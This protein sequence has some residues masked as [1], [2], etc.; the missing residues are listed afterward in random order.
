M[1]QSNR[2]SCIPNFPVMK[3]L[4]KKKGQDEDEFTE[5]PEQENAQDDD[6]SSL[7]D[8]SPEEG[9]RQDEDDR[10]EDPEEENA[11][12][13]EGNRQDEDDRS[14]DPEEE[15]AEDDDDSDDDYEAV[16]NAN[17]I[18]NENRKGI[19]R[20]LRLSISPR[21]KAPEIAI[22]KKKPKHWDVLP[23]KTLKGHPECL[24]DRLRETASDLI[25]KGKKTL[26]CDTGN[27]WEEESSLSFPTIRSQNRWVIIVLSFH[28]ILRG[29]CDDLFRTAADMVGGWAPLIM[30]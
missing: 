28:H 1:L 6:D 8:E 9:K 11:E 22:M 14:E 3:H 26:K 25:A 27:K 4:R 19:R 18:V 23:W 24:T 10:T 30:V 2:R 5:D 17:A 16:I 13:D 29:I 15:N 12:D 20:M 7:R 21:K